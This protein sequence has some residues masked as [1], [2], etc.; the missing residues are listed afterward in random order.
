MGDGFGAAVELAAFAFGDSSVHEGRAGREL[1]GLRQ[2]FEDDAAGLFHFLAVVKAAD[3]K[4]A[5]FLKARAQG[6]H[7]ISQVG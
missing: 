5:F 7:V 1:L 6:R 2:V 4:V 3:E